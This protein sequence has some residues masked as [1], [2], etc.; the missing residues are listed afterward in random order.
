[1]RAAQTFVTVTNFMESEQAKDIGIC[2]VQ[3]VDPDG[4]PE[5]SCARF[6]TLRVLFGKMTG[7]YL[8]LPR[9]FPGHHLTAAETRQSRVVDQVIGAFFFVRRELFRQLR[10]FDP[11]FSSTSRKST[12]RCAL[13]DTAYGRSF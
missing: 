3:L 11:R 1:V 2:G 13:A 7:L 4:A 6:P 9:L 10:G 8:P 12:L 5:F